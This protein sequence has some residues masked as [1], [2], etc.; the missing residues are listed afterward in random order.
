MAHSVQF[1]CKATVL[2]RGPAGIPLNFVNRFAVKV[3]KPSLYIPSRNEDDHRFFRFSWIYFLDRALIVKLRS[4]DLSC[5]RVGVGND[6]QEGVLPA[7]NSLQLVGIL[8]TNPL[9]AGSGSMWNRQR[10]DVVRCELPPAKKTAY[11]RVCRC[12]LAEQDDADAHSQRLAM[13]SD[14]DRPSTVLFGFL[15][16]RTGPS[17]SRKNHLPFAPAM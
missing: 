12:I 16:T 6:D 8:L 11:E 10:S 7:A 5:S 2:C 1:V 4:P 9:L 14:R 13:V 17:P 3:G 15:L